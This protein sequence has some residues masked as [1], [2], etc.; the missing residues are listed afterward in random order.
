LL[1]TALARQIDDLKEKSY[2][3]ESEE[4]LIAG[5]LRELRKY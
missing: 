5:L 2:L 1:K 4:K 3:Q